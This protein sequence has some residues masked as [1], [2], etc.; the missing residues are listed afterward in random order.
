MTLCPIPIRV[1]LVDDES[2]FTA[3]MAKRLG[4]LGMAVETATD[5]YEAYCI[6]ERAPVDV[7]VLDVLMP[8]L[9]GVQTLKALRRRFP[10]V[11]VIMLTGQGSVLDGIKAIRA[12]AFDFLFKPTEAEE[13]AARIREAVLTSLAR[14]A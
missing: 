1:L 6:L 10:G 2:E 14:N 5:G 4:R 3:V 11:P 13:L 12:G 9:D 8:G 7:V